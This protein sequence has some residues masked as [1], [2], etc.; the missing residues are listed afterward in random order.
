MPSLF[1]VIAQSRFDSI[2]LAQTGSRPSV[3][4]TD[5]RSAA[6]GSISVYFRQAFSGPYER[7]LQTL[8]AKHAVSE[9]QYKT[10]AHAHRQKLLPVPSTRGAD[11]FCSRPL[12]ISAS[13]STATTVYLVGR[14]GRAHPQLQQHS[15]RRGS[16]TI[17]P[18]QYTIGCGPALYH[19]PSS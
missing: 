4:Y 14:S 17:A 12:T 15:A 2:Y 7:N 3:P 19:R 9:F 1:S 18:S 5:I 11:L 6:S 8:V 10:G 16:I 13:P